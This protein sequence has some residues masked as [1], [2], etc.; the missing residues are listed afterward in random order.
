[1]STFEYFVRNYGYGALLIGTL[2][3]GETILIIGGLAARLGYLELPYVILVAFIGSLAGDQLAYYI[4]YFKGR[5]FLL[6]HPKW[7]RRVDR[8][9]GW[10]ERFHDVIMFGFRFIYG[11][12][13]I[14]PIVIGTRKDISKSRFA[15]L[16]ASGAAVWSMVVAAGGYFFGYAME[17]F[18]K[19]VKKYELHAV[20]CIVTIGLIVWM[21]QKY[22]NNRT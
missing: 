8:I 5:A 11:M 18:L 20:G 17:Q 1:M 14:T 19:D 12:R 22:R 10:L 16:N 9:D 21:I 6:R 3:E 4:G 13:L 15:F 2:I 7:Q